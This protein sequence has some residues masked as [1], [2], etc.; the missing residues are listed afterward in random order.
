MEMRHLLIPIL[1]TAFLVACVSPQKAAVKVSPPVADRCAGV[2][3]SAPPAH[4]V[5][6]N[7]RRF[8]SGSCQVELKMTVRNCLTVPIEVRQIQLL[9]GE[10]WLVRW[11]FKKGQLISPGDVWEFERTISRTGKHEL[12]LSYIA[13]AAELV[14]VKTV[15]E[16]TNNV[17]EAAR[18][19]C[20]ECNGSFTK[21]GMMGILSCRCRMDDVGRPC[22]DGR[23]CQGKCV[24]GDNGFACSK[25][26][27]VFGC[28]SYLPDGWSKR[29]LARPVRNRESVGEARRYLPLRIPHKCVD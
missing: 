25:F 27:T 23:D 3:F 16:A 22:K 6:E 5:C 26:R 10:D 1:A 17:L 14:V 15:V 19:K 7:K 12:V 20:K 2:V 4:A 9:T 28:H 11:V 8:W 13:D 29:K 24:A 18:K 21:H